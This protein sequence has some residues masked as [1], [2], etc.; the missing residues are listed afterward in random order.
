MIKKTINYTDY[1]GNARTEDHY[2]HFTQSEITEMELGVDGGLSEMLQKI[3]AAQDQPSLIKLFKKFVLDAYGE[4]TPDGRG[5]IK[6]DEDGHRL[7]NRF[8]QTEA[9]NVLFMELATNEEAAI[10]FVNGVV[11]KDTNPVP[12]P[13]LS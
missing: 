4:K 1:N 9:Y 8:A 3:I 12:A 7:A 13:A 6:V 10:K 11:P 2:F 5:F